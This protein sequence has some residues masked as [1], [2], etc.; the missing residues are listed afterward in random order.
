MIYDTPSGL[1]IYESTHK[2]YEQ[3]VSCI[4]FC[5]IVLATFF[6][7]K[8]KVFV[9]YF[10]I[11][12]QKKARRK[13]WKI[14]FIVPEKLFSFLRYSNFWTSSLS[15]LPLPSIAEFIRE[16]DWKSS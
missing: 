13:L 4:F 16:A 6:P 8:L 12:H 14:L 11:F 3:L 7:R 15:F 2:Q 9:C 1:W 5:R 10:Y